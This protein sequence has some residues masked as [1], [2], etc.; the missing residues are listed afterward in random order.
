MKKILSILFLALPILLTAQ[1]DNASKSK[2]KKHIKELSSDAYLGRGT[3]EEGERLAAN[4]IANEFAKMK[5]KPMGDSAYFHYF[6]FKHAEKNPHGD[7]NTNDTN[8]KIIK[9]KNV[10]AY[11]DNDAEFTIVIGGHYD[12][13]G[14]GHLGSSMEPN[15]E[16]QIHNGADDNASGT[17]GVIELARI[18]SSNKIKEGCN[19]IF[20]CFSGE[21]MGLIGSK[22]FASRADFDTSKIQAMINM[23]MI[24]RLNDSTYKLQVGGIGTSPDLG[25]IVQKLKPKELTISIDSSGTGP[26]DH[27]SF[28]L[29]NIPVL[30]FFTGTHA[31]Y[32]KPSDDFEKINLDGEAIIIN[33]IKNIVVDLASIPKMDFTKTVSKDNGKRTPFKVTLGIMPDYSFDGK[34]LKI[35]GV[36]DDKPAQQAGV[37]AGDI[38]LKI[39]DVFTDDI[40]KYMEVL[41]KLEKGTKTT[42]LVKRGTEEILLNVEF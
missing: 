10:V 35:D 13:L 34:G 17:A 26:S 21:E 1:Y 19:F 22:R 18:F 39:G 42:L 37:K 38:I 25:A 9:G 4:Y 7:E 16:G 33:Y 6:E 41:G 20:I 23:D 15:S 11:L 8:A 5:L 12:H 14:L 29:K 36:N 40:Y 24:G 3:G 27:T 31:D 32:H 28:Y 30:F 2:I